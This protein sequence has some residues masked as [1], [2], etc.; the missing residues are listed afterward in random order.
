M[1]VD[2][3]SLDLVRDL[4]GVLSPTIEP[5]LT[6][7]ADPPPPRTPLRMSGMEDD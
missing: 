3:L 7:N 6:L 5:C 2:V 1:K 4:F